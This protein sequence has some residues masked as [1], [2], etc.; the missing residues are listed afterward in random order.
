MTIINFIKI[1]LIAVPIFFLIDLTWLGLIAKNIYQKY[2]GHLM[3]PTPNWTAAVIFYLLF[4]VGLVIFAIYPAIRNNSW[5]YALLYGAM[6]G[7]FTYMTFDL[8]SLAVIKDWRWQIV[9][10]D[11]IWG[12]V[13]S[14]SV[15]V[16]AYLIGK[17]WL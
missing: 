2:M 17:N 8:T 7:F 4:I 14:S 15:S 9:I 1:Y 12:I 3:R 6:F 16:L 13:L 10:I 11:I 5:S